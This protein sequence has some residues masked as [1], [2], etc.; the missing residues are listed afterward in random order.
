M[1]FSLIYVLSVPLVPLFR[2]FAK[3]ALL[4]ARVWGVPVVVY[5]NDRTASHVIGALQQE[6]GLGYEP[7]GIFDDQTPAGDRI[8]G[9]PVLG[10]IEDSAH[11]IP[12]AI[13]GAPSIPRERL[14][15]LLEGP[16]S[17]YRRVIIIP[18]LLEIPSLWVST[19]DF[20]GVLGLEVERNLLNPPARGLKF[21]IDALIVLVTAPVWVPLCAVLAVLVR[22]IDGISPFY[23]Q[24]RVG[25]KGRTFRTLKFRTMVS[26]AEEVL[27][28]ELEE[29]PQLRE[30]WNY[31]C[32]LKDDPRI[33]HTGWFLRRTSLDEL[34]QFVNVLRGEMSLVGPRPLPAYHQ[35]HL[36]GSVRRLRDSV[37]PGI[38]GLWQVSGRSASGTE[39]MIRWDSYYVR[40]WSLWLD[41]VI[42]ARTFR[43]ILNREGAY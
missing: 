41:I 35:E 19:R 43:T 25:H 5:G 40:N 6:A 26:N 8:K 20:I 39:G 28:K 12:V 31:D 23:V 33:T 18:D 1:K 38:T 16:L 3:R 24:E 13:L 4:R 30:E 27:E 17:H 2:V 21:L 36:P 29:N 10:G 37:R 34:P 32:K 15:E 7:Y 9:V 11:G 14:V 42:M 22:M